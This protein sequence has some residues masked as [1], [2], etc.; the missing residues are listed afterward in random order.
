MTRQSQTNASPVSDQSGTALRL[1]DGLP[2]DAEAALTRW[3]DALGDL[4]VDGWLKAAMAVAPETTH[5]AR[6]R[7][8]AAFSERGMDLTAWFV[9][10]LVGTAA[11]GACSSVRR[12]SNAK[13]KLLVEARVAAE[14][15]ALAIAA[16][17]WLSEAD[18][19]ALC[20]P[21]DQVIARGALRLVQDS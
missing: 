3:L 7:V 12:L 9:R 15:T 20:A 21:F 8:I 19:D 16:R 18:H 17:D 11:H 1:L 13:R 5:D 10:D 6:H 4:S 14:C 2:P